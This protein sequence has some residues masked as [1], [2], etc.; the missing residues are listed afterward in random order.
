ML[1]NRQPQKKQS[2]VDG[3]QQLNSPE[4]YCLHHVADQGQARIP[5][6]TILSST[7]IRWMAR[8]HYENE[9]LHLNSE[10]NQRSGQGM[11]V[12]TVP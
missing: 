2:R 9:R 6:S 4:T 11:I 7:M 5:F 12:F 8:D 3:L 10:M 1:L